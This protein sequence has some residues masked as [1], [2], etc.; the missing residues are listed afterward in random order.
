MT[1]LSNGVQPNEHVVVEGQFNLTSG[2]R[3]AE[4]RPN[5]RPRPPRARPRPRPRPPPRPIPHQHRPRDNHVSEFFIRRPVATILLAIGIFVA[6][7]LA[8]RLLPVASLPEVDYPTISVSA[9]LAGASPETMANSV[10]TP[11]IKQFQTI[12]GIDEITARNSL[13]QHQHRPAVRS[14][15]EHRCRRRRRSGRDL[16]RSPP[17]AGRDGPAELPQENPADAPILLLAV[18]SPTLPLTDVDDLAENVISPSLSTIDGVAEVTKYSAADLCGAGRRRP[19]QARRPR[20]RSRPGA[21]R[22]RRR[23]QPESRSA[24]SKRLDQTLTSM[25]IPNCRTPRPSGR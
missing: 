12:P 7:L 23:Q 19:R 2:Q 5:R 4:S 8:V 22:D 17:P 10:A 25:P 9:S 13:G 15:P 1:G 21:N 24:P 14:R 11:L 20:H 18:Q 16:R 3:V 6:G